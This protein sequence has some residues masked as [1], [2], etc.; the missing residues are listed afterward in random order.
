MF[1]RTPQTD[2][3]CNHQLAPDGDVVL[4]LES[5]NAPFAIFD[6]AEA[7]A[8]PST[9]NS[10]SSSTD[11]VTYLVSSHHL[12]LAS[13]VF[14]AALTGPWIESTCLE[15]GCHRIN[16]KDWDAEALL[17]VL[18]IIH[19]RNNHVPKTVSLEMLC[20][21]SVMVDYYH[22]HEAVRFP[23]LLWVD[24]LRPSVPNTYSRDLIIWL[25][26]SWIFQDDEMFKLATGVAIRESTESVSALEL[27]IAEAV[28]GKSQNMLS[29]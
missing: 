5:A 21:I 20:K 11:S 3:P 19:G 10:P 13:P 6:D 25:C 8:S 14:R 2:Q 28:I 26:V 29:R 23:I 7:S 16:I 12:K 18:N 1:C 22:V 4:L 15:D 17:I 24:A 27:P 9:V